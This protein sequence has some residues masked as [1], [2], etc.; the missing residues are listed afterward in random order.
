MDENPQEPQGQWRP[1]HGRGTKIVAWIILIG[2]AAGVVSM[3][4]LAILAI[5][6]W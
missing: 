3:L 4:I 1:P 6:G 2:V 5:V